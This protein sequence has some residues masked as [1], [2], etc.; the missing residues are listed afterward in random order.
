MLSFAFDGITSFSVK[1]LRMILGLG[2][3]ILIG[4]IFIMIYSIVV[5]FLGQT[6]DGW[7]FIML[8]IWFIG[9][10]QMVSIGVIGEYIG[11]MYNET[12]QR[13]R[14]IIEEVVDNN[15]KDN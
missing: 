15:E 1:P 3:I 13:P 12:K 4:S 8:S 11:K 14:Y 2:F 7:T 5:K 10:V 9:G 6:V